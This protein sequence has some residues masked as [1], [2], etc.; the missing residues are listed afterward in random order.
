MLKKNEVYPVKITGYTTEGLGVCRID[1]QVVFVHGALED[2]EAD[3]LILKVGKNE[4]FA[5]VKT[6]KVPSPHRIVPDCPYDKFCGGC[7]LRHMTYEEECRMKARRVRDA[8]TRIGGVDPGE[9]P[10]LAAEDTENYRN[11]AI[12]SVGTVDGK[13]DAGFYRARTHDLI[14]AETCKIQ[15]LDAAKLRTAAVEWMRKYN[16][17]VYD[18]TA[19]R[20]LVRHIYVRNAFGTGQVM[21]CLVV[22]GKKLPCEQELVEMLRAAVPQLTTVVLC[23]NT[24]KGNAILGSEFRTL[25]GSGAIDDILCGLTFRLSPRSFYQVNRQQAQRL[26]DLA[27]ARAGLTETDTVLDL[28]CGTGTITLCMAKKCGRAIGVEIIEAAIADAK[29]NAARNGIENAEFFCADAGSAARKLAEEGIRPDVITVDPPRKGLSPDVIEAVGKMDPRRVV[30]IS[31]DP[32]TLARD[33]ARF[34]EIGYELKS[35]DA[36]DLF[37]RCHHVESVVVLERER[38]TETFLS[39]SQLR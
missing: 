37:P 19:H 9:V 30:Y 20:G 1:G 8:L 15:S 5:K 35:A 11:K 17:P 18:E 29:E 34:R 33:V 31:C 14:A 6:L 21:A 27:I 2:E 12:F 28:Y 4:A 32:A 38:E 23:E 39:P 7:A 13:A 26:Y 24:R 3:V 16:V 36:A 22:N 25:F 10:I